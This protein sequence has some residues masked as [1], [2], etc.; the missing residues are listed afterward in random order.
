MEAI[1]HREACRHQ[2]AVVCVGADER[3]RLEQARGRQV[4]G[5]GRCQ[6]EQRARRLEGGEDRAIPDARAGDLGR[7]A[8][9]RRAAGRHR[10]DG[11]RR[12]PM[13]STPTIPTVSQMVHCPKR[14]LA[15]RSSPPSCAIA[16]EGASMPVASAIASGIA[17]NAGI[18]EASAISGAGSCAWTG[19]GP[20]PRAPRRSRS[21]PAPGRGGWRSRRRP[22]RGGRRRCPRHQRRQGQREQDP[23]GLQPRDVRDDRRRPRGAADRHGDHEVHQ[24]GAERDERPGVAEGGADAARARRL[25]RGSAGSAGDR[26]PRSPRSSR[27]PAPSSGRGRR[28]CRRG[29]ESGL[30]RIGDR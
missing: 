23:L 6:Q 4:G 5:R 18:S 21:P 2:A 27:S 16:S 22:C 25:P 12:D 3:Q 8:W 9:S 29:A 14:R 13:V 17:S 1:E 7:A 26:W 20:G 30:D 10:G 19:A 15:S 11:E 28:G 24:Q